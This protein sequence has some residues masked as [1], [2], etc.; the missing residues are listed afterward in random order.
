VVKG[1]GISALNFFHSIA[2]SNKRYNSIDSLLIGCRL[3]FNQAEISEQI[4]QFYQ[5][6]FT[7]QC[8]WRLLV[9]GLPFD[10]ISD[11]EVFWL[12][13]DFGNEKVRKVVKAMV[14]DKTPSLDSFSMA[15]S[16]ACW[17]V[18]RVDIMKV[19]IDFHARDKFEKSL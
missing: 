15:F 14:G 7:E 1:R 10:S 16:Q 6:L 17:D 18:L 19:F 13:R 8:S 5:K 2:N 11:Y 9:D 12:E 4:G 3:S